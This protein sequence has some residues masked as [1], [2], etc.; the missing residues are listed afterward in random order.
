MD[1]KYLTLLSNYATI[2]R[3][4]SDYVRKLEPISMGEIISLESN[5]NQ[6]HQFPASLRELLFLA[7][8]YCH[9]LEYGMNKS[10]QEMQ[11][12]SRE[13]LIDAGLNIGRPFFVIDVYNMSDQFLFVYL[14]ENV[15]DPE[16]QSAYMEQL[17]DVSFTR[18]LK[19]TLSQFIDLR[20]KRLLSGENPY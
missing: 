20:F 2:Q 17:A 9:V 12:D 13:R 15:N 6:G 11:E 18:S 4:N 16:V 10:Q 5:Y 7:G 19:S 14:D 1:I 8:N 3:P